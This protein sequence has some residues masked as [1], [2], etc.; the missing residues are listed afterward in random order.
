M[1]SINL[2]LRVNLLIVD[3]LGYLPMVKQRANL[4][5]RL[6]PRRYE[7]GPVILTFNKLFQ[8]SF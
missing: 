5:F 7:K 4:S 2:L 6:G 8:R 3:E 1:S